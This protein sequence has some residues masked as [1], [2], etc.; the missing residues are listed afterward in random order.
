MFKPFSGLLILLSMI[1]VELIYLPASAQCNQWRDK[2][3][4]RHTYCKYPNQIDYRRRF[5]NG[6]RTKEIC[7][8]Y[9]NQTD[10][11]Y[12]TNG[13]RVKKCTFSQFGNRC[14]PINSSFPLQPLQPLQPLAPL[15]PIQPK[16]WF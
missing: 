11:T 9:P 4:T 13:M 3:G 14:R 16:R 5:R 8:Q 6:T 7:Y 2:Q 12:Y 1:G 10:C 15:A